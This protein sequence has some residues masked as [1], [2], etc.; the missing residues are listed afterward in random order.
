MAAPTLR[1][2][3]ALGGTDSLGT[4][5]SML[6]QYRAVAV[7]VAAVVVLPSFR[8]RPLE[9]ALR[10]EGVARLSSFVSLHPRAAPR[11]H[12]R[13]SSAPASASRLDRM[14]NDIAERS[15]D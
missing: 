7:A 11:S 12:Q 14:A 3:G 6:E 5:R 15:E 2:G 8:C 13:T 4:I 10:P 1:P 9:A